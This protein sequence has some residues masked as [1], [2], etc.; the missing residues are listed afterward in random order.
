M[1]VWDDGIGISSESD[2]WSF[3]CTLVE[4][5]T[6]A[7]PYVEQFILYSTFRSYVLPAFSNF[8][9]QNLVVQL[10]RFKC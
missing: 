3:G 4:M 10:G 2:A 7:I 6:G 9:V 1:V 5:C 8:L